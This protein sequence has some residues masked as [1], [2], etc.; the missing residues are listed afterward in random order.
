MSHPLA[1]TQTDC[2]NRIGVRGDRSCPE[3]ATVVHC[4]NCPVFAAAGRRFLDAPYPDGYLQEWAQR[5]AAPREEAATDLKSVLIFR[6]DEEWLALPVDVLIEVTTPRPIHRVPHRGGLLAGL[7]NIRGELQLCVR[8]K[9]LLG[10]TGRENER[11]EARK[12]AN[13]AL[14]RLLVVQ[15]EAERWVFPV[16]EVAQVFRFP[17]HE[18][19]RVPATL[20]RS[21]VRFSRGVFVWQGH[22]VGYLDEASLFQRLRTTIR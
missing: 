18:L 15:R 4:H 10:I 16:D 7:V 22:S 8:L 12:P 14:A 2:W 9:Q 5:L 21:A 3:L 20:A 6:L 13:A 11:E 17:I 19:T 1:I